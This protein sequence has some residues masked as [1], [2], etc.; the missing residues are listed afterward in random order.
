[1]TIWIRCNSKGREDTRMW[2]EGKCYPATPS[3]PLEGNLRVIDNLG[4]E[5]FVANRPYPCFPM[6]TS[7]YWPGMTIHTALFEKVAPE[8]V[9]Q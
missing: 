9:G 3:G 5:R 4:H 7:G 2:T 6:G 1:M 8:E